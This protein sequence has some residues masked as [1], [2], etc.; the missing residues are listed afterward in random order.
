[1]YFLLVLQFYQCKVL[2]INKECDIV[3]QQAERM[4]FLLSK[5]K[6][7][8]LHECTLQ[9]FD[10]NY[11][12]LI[13]WMQGTVNYLIIIFCQCQDASAINVPQKLSENYMDKKQQQKEIALMKMYRAKK[14]Y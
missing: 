1:M 6:Y 14:L 11:I 7:L 4:N 13:V 12:L 9:T 10:F 8:Y 5:P 3:I 2:I